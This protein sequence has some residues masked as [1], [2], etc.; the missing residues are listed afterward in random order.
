MIELKITPKYSKVIDISKIDMI[1]FEKLP[2]GS[3]VRI[4]I[5]KEH[6]ILGQWKVPKKYADEFRARLLKTSEMKN[7]NCLMENSIPSPK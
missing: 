4:S 7:D 1:D 3:D 5:H 6:L 2:E